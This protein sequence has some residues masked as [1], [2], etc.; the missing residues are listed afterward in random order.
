MTWGCLGLLDRAC[1]WLR[2]SSCGIAWLVLGWLLVW[3]VWFG[4]GCGAWD[5]LLRGGRQRR[6]EECGKEEQDKQWDGAEH[7]WLLAAVLGTLLLD[8]GRLAW[9]VLQRARRGPWIWSCRLG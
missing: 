3:G 5:Y 7:Y 2:K 4:H 9:R 1:T 6:A 8:L